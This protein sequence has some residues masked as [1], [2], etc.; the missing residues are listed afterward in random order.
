MMITYAE[1]TW[2]PGCGNFGIQNVVKNIFE[3]MDKKNIVIVGGIGCHAKILDYLDVNNFYS[4]HG[5]AVPAGEGIKLA[6]PK[7]KV[8]VFVGDGDVYGEG[9]SHLIFAA[10]RNIDITVVVH[11]NRVYGLTTGQFTPVSPFGFKGKSTPKGSVEHPLNPLSLMLDVGA[12]FIG[13]TYTTKMKQMEDMITKAINHKGFS[14]VDILQPCFTFYNTYAD[15]NKRT[16]DAKTPKSFE[17][18]EKLIREW[19]YNSTTAKIPLGVFYKKN[20]KT[21]EELELIGKK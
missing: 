19:D 14:I 5:R 17:E 2:C 4:L 1:N 7:L 11:N 3:K 6:N 8:V 13:R 10:K 15:Y 18:T 16:Y 21:Y 12:T 9:I 20:K